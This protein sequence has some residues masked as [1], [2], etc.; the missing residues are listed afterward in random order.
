M[1]T[2][3]TA[4]IITP[5]I[6]FKINV[7]SHC[8]SPHLSI[9]REPLFTKTDQHNSPVCVTLCTSRERHITPVVTVNTVGPFLRHGKCQGLYLCSWISFGHIPRTSAS[10]FSIS[11]VLK[12]LWTTTVFQSKVVEQILYCCVFFLWYILTASWM[13]VEPEKVNAVLE[14]PQSNS[15]K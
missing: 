12:R 8:W 10:K 15:V 11:P 3:V 6:I 14:W 7:F 2:S 5:C 1:A 13:C 9:P 4:L